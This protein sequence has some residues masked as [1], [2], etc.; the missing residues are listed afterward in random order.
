MFSNEAKNP[1][2]NIVT[3]KPIL[4]VETYHR[5]KLYHSLG[6]KSKHELIEIY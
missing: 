1:S 2:P 5:K 3:Q 4:R 6:A